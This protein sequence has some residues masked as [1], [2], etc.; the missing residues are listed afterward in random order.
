MSW[1][2]V[3]LALA[4]LV[5]AAPPVAASELATVELRAV[6]TALPLDG[7]TELRLR[8][9]LS[10]GRPAD[11][12]DADIAVTSSVPGM[13][14]AN[15]HGRKGTARAGTLGPGPTTLTV[16]VT[17]DGVTVTDELPMRVLPEPARPYRHAY[18]Q[19]LT[20]KMFLAANQDRVSLTFEQAL[21]VMR[22]VDNL[23]RGIPKIF[24][25]VGWQYNGHDTGYPA[26][27]VVNANLKRPQDANALDSLRWLIA[28][29]RKYHTTVSFHINMLD[30][31]PQ[32]PLWQTYLDSDVIARNAD[33]SLR[34][35]VW[36]YPISY[37]LEWNAGLT[38][39]R[40][41]TLFE[42]VDM[43]RIGT[44]HVD[45]FHQ[46]IPG[47]GTEP[48][49]PYH[50]VTTDQE[51]ETQ[52][53]II[54]YWR[55]RGVD[56]TSEFTYSYRKD[57]LLGLQPM[58]WHFRN[59]NQMVIPPALHVG[60]DGGDPRFG[61][62]MSGES[63]IRQNPVALPGFLDQFAT[64][65]LLWHY[66]NRLGRVSDINGV[67]TFSDGTT[68]AVTDGRLVVRRGDFLLRDGNDVFVPAK[69]LRHKEI[70]AYSGAGYEART[71]TLPPDWRDVRY[72]DVYRIGQEGSTFLTR[73]PA[74]GS[75][76][77]SLPA[78][79]AVSIVPAGH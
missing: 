70:V 63:I 32:S 38:R 52:K 76:T 24:Y 57:P 15:L 26:W 42:M 61:T 49:S 35:Y 9:T 44:V 7:V 58:A 28:E 12:G 30:A 39:K 29:A 43:R 60:G 50:G 10:N 59:V 77:L 66:L 6:S 46:Y 33:G 68:S 21:D 51:V 73:Q 22:R 75:V 56:V 23:T 17:L 45:A 16:A 47:Y 64:T 19:T 4:M 3:L 34:S 14:S 53:K 1:R 11:L 69:W 25:L 18:H 54:R 71:W 27:D 2:A 36:G 37:T 31:S 72:V 78:G 13:V 40:I 41:D 55:D 62:T 74:G 20:M 79:A 65:T 8:A 5:V 48:I 67:V